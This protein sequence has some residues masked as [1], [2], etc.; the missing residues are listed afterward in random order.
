MG[1]SQTKDFEEM[2]TYL[3]ISNDAESDLDEAYNWYELQRKGLGSDFLLRI[4]EA[5]SI[6]QQFPQSNQCIY[7]EVRRQLV[8]RFPY[9]IFYTYENEIINVIAVFHSRRDSKT[10]KKRLH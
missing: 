5:L 7:F 2:N 1:R 8:R 9:G 3:I 4:E 10:W 6:L